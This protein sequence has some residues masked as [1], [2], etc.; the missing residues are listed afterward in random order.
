M[1]QMREQTASLVGSVR[2]EI[3]GDD[4][5]PLELS[6]QRAWTAY[7]LA[8]IE[9]DAFGAQSFAWIAL[10]CIFEAIKEIEK[11]N[12]QAERTLS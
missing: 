5:V 8:C 2:D 4:T 9:G 6:L 1:S 10:G 3:L 7:R 11:A 12:E